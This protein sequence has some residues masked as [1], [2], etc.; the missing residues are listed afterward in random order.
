MQE[1]DQPSISHS[2][3]PP[4][5]PPKV[6]PTYSENTAN[7]PISMLERC[8]YNYIYVW[9]KDRRAFWMYPVSL[10]ANE[11]LFGYQWEDQFWNFIK[12]NA[13]QISNFY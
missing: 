11:M 13:W 4:S 5:I 3:T 6:I 7:I 8:L 9:T 2:Y 1:D 12:I 10:T